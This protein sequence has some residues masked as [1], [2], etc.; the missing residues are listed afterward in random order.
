MMKRWLAL[1]MACV[2]TLCGCAGEPSASPTPA[3]EAPTVV[4]TESAELAQLRA[5][6]DDS[7]AILGV[8]YLGSAELPYF[9]DLSVYLEANGFGEKYPFLY[10]VPEERLVRQ[11]G[12]DIIAV[13]PASSDVTLSVY[14]YVMD[15]DLMDGKPGKELLTVTDG[16][17]AIV[18]GTVTENLSNL[19]IQAKSSSGLCCDYMPYMNPSFGFLPPAEGAYDFTATELL[20]QFGPGN[21]HEWWLALC[22]TWYARHYNGDDELMAMALTLEADGRA[23]YAYGYPDGEVLERF[24]GSW[25]SPEDQQIVLELYGGPQNSEGST[26]SGEAYEMECSLNYTFNG[27]TL[28]LDHVEGTPLLHGTDA[29]QFEFLYFDGFYL[30]GDWIARSDYW[31][32]EYELRLF[33]TG[34]CWFD[35]YDE[36]ETLL[37][38]YEGWWSVENDVLNLSMILS[39]GQH[40]ETPE[41]DYIGGSYLV[42]LSGTDVLTLEYESGHILTVNME[43]EGNEIF[44]LASGSSAVSV[45]YA[46][47]VNAD[48]E[49]CDWVIIDDTDP[50]EAAFCTTVPVEDFELVSLLLEDIS[51]DGT[52]MNWEVTPLFEYGTLEPERPLRVVLTIYGTIPSYGIS[53]T[54]PGGTSRLFAVTM[55]GLDG[56]LELM[57][58]R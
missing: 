41:L 22:D 52:E 51:Q 5:D 39:Y 45:H 25:S 48:W 50:V 53:F 58:I 54:D 24:E 10:E 30:M 35:I 13:V 40:P 3:P 34:E 16:Q 8:A 36:S 11:D 29:E 1:A 21:G 55:S 12:C 37:T 19:F 17:P 23:E 15:E 28:V 4:P 7:G 49:N 26:T 9:E 57:E 27:N 20:G 38:M 56:S 31:G 46:Q 18:I 33:D 32:W 6:I 2:I 43:G 44:K 42:S 14:E 47:D